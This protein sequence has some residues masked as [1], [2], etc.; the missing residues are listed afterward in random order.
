[1]IRYL[2]RRLLAAIPVFLGITLLVFAMMNLAPGTIADLRGDQ[3]TAAEQA[4][5]ARSLHLD[6]PLPVR[7]VLWVTGVLRGDFGISYRTGQAV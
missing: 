7:Y 3:T 5:V 1:M 6:Q 2:I 4:A